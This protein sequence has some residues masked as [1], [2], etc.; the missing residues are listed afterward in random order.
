MNNWQEWIAG[1]NPLDPSSVLLMQTPQT[2]SSPAG[3]TVTWLSVS[4][5]T[6]FLQQ[7]TN[8]AAQPA[9]STIQSNIMGQ[10]GTT[11]FIDATATNGGPYFYR[12]G[13]QH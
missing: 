9:F 3:V 2:S 12:A 8:L 7:A 4:N 10:V 5:R 1:L 13:V 11:S 6:Y